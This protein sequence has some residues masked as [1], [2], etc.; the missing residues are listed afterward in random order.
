MPCAALMDSTVTQ[1]RPLQSM[2]MMI[3][4]LGE[5][6]AAARAFGCRLSSAA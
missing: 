2:M 4:G 1:T 6:T 5:Y 3:P